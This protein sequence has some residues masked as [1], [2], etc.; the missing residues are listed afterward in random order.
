MYFSLTVSSDI[1][2]SLCKL[3]FCA[4]WLIISLGFMN[5]NSASLP[6]SSQ[7]TSL[8]ST[9]MRCSSFCS[10]TKLGVGTLLFGGAHCYIP[11]SRAQTP[12]SY[13]QWWQ[14][15]ASLLAWAK[16]QPPEAARS[17]SHIRWFSFE[18]L[19]TTSGNPTTGITTTELRTSLLTSCGCLYFILQV[20]NLVGK[21]DKEHSLL[22]IEFFS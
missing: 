18:D 5:P 4:D 16:W 3:A 7:W 14:D 17:H 22:S 1:Y 12:W 8:S 15:L 20:F 2:L 11:Y 13:R 19:S 10:Q 21:V 9:D 6:S